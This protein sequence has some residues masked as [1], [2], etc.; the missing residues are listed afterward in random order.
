M[1]AVRGERG[2]ATI[3][4]LGLIPVAV[5]VGIAVFCVLAAGRARELAD[6][7]AGAGAVALLQGG[8]PEAAARR[9]IARSAGS[10]EVTVRGR[11]VTVEVRPHL[12]LRALSSM[13]AATCSADAGPEPSA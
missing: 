6:H 3:E 2:Q 12:P 1:P 8:D 5:A 13:L 7:A 9:A 11:M 4:L 10:F